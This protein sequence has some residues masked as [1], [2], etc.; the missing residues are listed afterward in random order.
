MKNIN[1][2]AGR[3]YNT[4]GVRF[5]A[6]Y[7]G[8]RDQVSGSYLAVLWEKLVRAYAIDAR[9]AEDCKRVEAQDVRAWLDGA[10]TCKEEVFKS[11]GLGDDVRLESDRIVAACLRVEEHP[12]HVEA[13]AQGMAG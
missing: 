2:L 10:G 13:F 9:V 5:P 4:L 12:V 8:K 3:G 7:C 1:W 6:R 11:A